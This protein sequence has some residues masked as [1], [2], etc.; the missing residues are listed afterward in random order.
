MSILI[1]YVSATYQICPL[2]FCGREHVGLALLRVTPF[3]DGHPGTRATHIMLHAQR[4]KQ[5]P[6]AA[7]AAE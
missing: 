6:A 4:C 2:V 7:T 3:R 1:E 5:P